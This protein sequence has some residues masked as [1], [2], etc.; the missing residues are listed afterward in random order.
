ME[1]AQGSFI[2]REVRKMEKISIVRRRLEVAPTQAELRARQ[3]LM[4]QA[5][6]PVDGSAALALLTEPGDS[7]GIVSLP[8]PSEVVTTEPLTVDLSEEAKAELWSGGHLDE[9]PGGSRHFIVEAARDRQNDKIVLKLEFMRPEYYLRLLTT[10]EVCEMLHVS[11]SSL[12]HY[13]RTGDLRTHRMGR[14][15]RFRFQD[16]LD[17][18]TACQ[19]GK[20]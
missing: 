9:T 7:A 5:S 12:Y 13:A 19:I 20:P 15:L 17:F 3:R 16:V 1:L 11:T 14:A 18:I 10:E 2:L 4:D 8:M 6:A